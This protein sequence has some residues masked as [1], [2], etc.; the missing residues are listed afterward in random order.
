MKLYLEKHTGCLIPLFEPFRQN[1]YF[2][3]QFGHPVF[4]KIKAQKSLGMINWNMEETLLDMKSEA[5]CSEDCRP[6]VL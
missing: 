6:F 2:K 5:I 3:F 1:K 4:W